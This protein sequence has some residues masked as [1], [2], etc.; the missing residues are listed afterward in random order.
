MDITREFIRSKKPCTA[1]YR[2]YLKRQEDL[3]GYQQLLDDLVQEGHIADAC[4]LLDQLGP[5]DDVLTLDALHAE[6]FVYA[7]SVVCK[8]PIEVGT[9]MRTGASLA[10]RGGV[11][12]GSQLQVGG[13]LRVEGSV[14]CEGPFAVAGDTR[15]EWS[16]RVLGAVAAGGHLRVGWEADCGGPAVV[17]RSVTVGQDLVAG[18]D[19][20]CRSGMKVGGDVHVAGTL[21][22]AQGVQQSLRVG[23][24]LH[25]GWLQGL[26]AAHDITADGSIRV[27]ETL[28]AGG[29]IQSGQDYG[30]FAGLITPWV[31]GSNGKFVRAA[32]P[33]GW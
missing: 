17:Q 19:F 2:W 20:S 32:R 23:G 27:G 16:L 33:K 28:Q 21:E 29:Q 9:V 14:Q 7:G 12:V 6:A 8:G 3:S 24:H 1:G 22:V 25:C 5:T 11:R 4:W 15:V 30:V 31:A 18:A 26:L 10:V 13:D